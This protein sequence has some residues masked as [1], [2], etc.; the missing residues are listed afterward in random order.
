MALNDGVTATAGMTIVMKKAPK[1]FC[2]SCGHHIYYLIEQ[3]R[4]AFLDRFAPVEGGE[5]CKGLDCPV[6]K[7][8]FIGFVDKQPIIK[9]DG[10]WRE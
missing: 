1:V 7:N 4:P 2:A 8:V 5:S 3:F 9:T 10:G 6:C